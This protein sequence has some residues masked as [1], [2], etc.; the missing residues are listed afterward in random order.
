MLSLPERLMTK[1]YCFGRLEYYP[2]YPIFFWPG[3]GNLIIVGKVGEIV[4]QTRKVIPLPRFFDAIKDIYII[5]LEEITFKEIRRSSYEILNKHIDNM[6]M[7]KIT[8]P[9]I[10]EWINSLG[11]L[12]ELG[13]HT[14]HDFKYHYEIWI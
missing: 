9:V 8:L 3:E 11:K 6:V 14:I 4:Y 12:E 13:N 7:G 5:K 2:Y 1:G 10:R